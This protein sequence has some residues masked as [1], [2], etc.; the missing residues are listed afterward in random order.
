MKGSSS[1]RFAEAILQENARGF[2]AVI[3]DI[4]CFSPK[5]GDLLRGRD[6][7]AAALSL[8][9]AGSPLL[10]VVTEREN[11]GG[12]AALL[13]SITQSANVPVLRK[14]FIKNVSQLAETAELG[15]SAVL[16]IS[17]IIDE[18]TLKMLYEKSIDLGLEPFVEAHTAEELDAARALGARLIGINN[19]NIITLE[20]D[21]GGPRRTAALMSGAAALAKDTGRGD[22]GTGAFA[23]TDAR[24]GARTIGDTTDALIISESG[25]VSPADAALAVSAGANAILVGTALWQAGDMAAMY[26]SLRVERKNA[27]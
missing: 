24:S 26:R 27:P 9:Q 1:G 13:R 11:F 16:L 21:E 2:A 7:A 4:K 22:G 12:S 3:P 8:V 17:A 18:A 19:R 23:R 10:S 25:I 14:D 15:A 6:P 5:E 20:R